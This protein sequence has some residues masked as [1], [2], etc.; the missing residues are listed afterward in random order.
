M[1]LKTLKLLSIWGELPVCIWR[2]VFKR[3]ILNTFTV[4]M[5]I[6]LFFFN[7]DIEYE[8]EI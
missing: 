7:L 6:K 4:I 3:F 5:P 2:F 8:K 1:G